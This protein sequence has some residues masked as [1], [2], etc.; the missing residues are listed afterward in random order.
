MKLSNKLFVW[1]MGVS[2]VWIMAGCAG[3]SEEGN[4]GEEGESNQELRAA[5][6]TGIISLDPFSSNHGEPATILASR[7]IY[8]TLVVNDGSEFIGGLAE[9]W[10]QE[11][12]L[13]WTFTLKD[14]ITFH[15][16]SEV[17]AEDVK[18]SLEQL[19]TRGESPLTVLWEVFDSVEAEDDKTVTIKTTE[20]LGTMLSNLSLL[21]IV[22]A[23]HM[24]QE[25][26]FMNPIGSGPF[27]VESFTPEQELILSGYDE[28]WDGAPNLDTLELVNI[29]ETSS[30]M[31]AIETGEIDL[32]WTIPND[33]VTELEGNED[34][35]L[36]ESESY[37]Y[38]FNWFN[39][40]RE[41]F[42]NPKV[43][44]ALWHAL[45][46][47]TIVNDLFGATGEV[48]TSPIPNAVYGHSEQSPYE[49]DPELAKELLAEAGYPDGFTTTMM[50][51]EGG[52]PQILE[53]QNIMASYWSEIGVEIEPDRLERAEWIEKLN[54]LDWDM[55][56]QT[57]SVITGD[58]DYTLG[59]LYISEANRN[60]YHNEELDQLLL[61]AK[62]TTDQEER[63]SL[64]DQ[65]NQ[66]IWDEAVGIFPVELKQIHAVRSNVKGF[67][68]D[69]ASAPRLHQVSIE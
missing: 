22:P 9:D 65:V 64:Y 43:R 37:L 16:G 35:N 62:Q 58:A 38:Y 11:D 54:A 39:S 34:I 32:S 41:P 19:I 31:T 48:M 20:P 55:D 36:V 40:S 45:D 27:S 52:G 13:T 5:Y 67:E 7:Q 10:E 47:E 66:I 21:F 8:D 14:D 24:E 12:D 44:R 46:I 23:D 68:P 4:S 56:L 33:Q 29:P 25:D 59:R 6:D 60:G 49:Y 1:F 28:Y 26:F 69:P 63:A 30:R 17:T 3:L 57:N 42:D 18:V 51:N 50:W 15:D 53:L 2:L 61:D